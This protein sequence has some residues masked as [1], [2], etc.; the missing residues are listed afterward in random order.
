[1]PEDIRIIWLSIISED[2][3]NE[4][5]YEDWEVGSLAYQ[6]LK[7]EDDEDWDD[8]YEGEQLNVYGV[9]C[10]TLDQWL[11]KSGAKNTEVVLI[12]VWRD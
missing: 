10:D 4:T 8:E 12:G 7:D 1:M 11:I 3:S 2:S 5:G 9:A 6:N